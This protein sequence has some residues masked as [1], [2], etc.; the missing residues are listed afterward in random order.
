MDSSDT[1]KKLKRTR[2]FLF[3]SDIGAPVVCIV[4]IYAYQPLLDVVLSSVALVCVYYTRYTFGGL[5]DVFYYV[6]FAS[7]PFV[8]G[9]CVSIIALG[10][11]S[12]ASLTKIFTIHIEQ[13]GK[14]QR[15]VARMLGLTSP[16]IYRYIVLPQ[17]IKSM[18][19]LVIGVLK[20]LLRS[21]S[22]AGYIAQ[23]DLVKAVDAIR[24]QTFDAFVPLLFISL[25]Y[26][27]LSWMIVHSVK[28][29]SSKFFHYD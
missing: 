26:L 2:Y 20:L 24:A 13:V 27:A 28:M 16:Q 14:E 10:V 15:E 6:V 12:S 11:Y 17:T 21:T 29:L 19:P 7:V 4:D 5:D 8:N 1:K 25:L 23:K 9:V 22:Y 18:L 3:W